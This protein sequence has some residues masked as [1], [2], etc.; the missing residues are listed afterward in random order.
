[1]GVLDV[2]NWQGV[3]VAPASTKFTVAPTWTRLDALDVKLRVAE[4][5]IRRGRSDEF[6]RTDTGTCAVGFKDRIGAVDPSAVNWISRPFAFAVRNPVTDTW[7]PRFRGHVEEHGWNL[8]PARLMGEVVIEAADALSYFAKVEM[9]P[10]ADVDGVP[11]FGHE[12][13]DNAAGRDIAGNVFY[14]GTLVEGPKLRIEA[15]LEQAG[16]PSGLRSIFTGN[17]NLTE[18]V[19][20][21]GESILAVMHDAADAE[22]PGVANLFVD[23]YGVVCFHG[24]NARFAPEDTADTATHWD[25]HDWSLG[26]GAT[27]IGSPFHVRRSSSM[28]RNSALC[29]PQKLQR[30]PESLIVFPVKDRV[31]QFVK[32]DGSI[33]LHGAHSW[34]ATDLVVKEGITSGLTGPQECRSYA[35]YIIA[36]YS[37]PQ[38]RL[39]QV[40]IRPVRPSDPRAHDIW[41]LLCN[42][43]ISDR[44][45]VGMAHPGGGGVSET[46]FVEGISETW[47]PLQYDLD[48]GYPF[49]EMVLDLSPAAYWGSLP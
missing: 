24:R 14:E 40:T 25:F 23:R 38:M 42:V 18:T 31:D 15:A 49:C 10:G 36:N 16:W 44:V 2:F 33:S 41:D 26:D 43:D 17:V 3:T 29:Y 47:R 1:M 45:T 21:P 37:Q 35:Q 19:Y 48:T 28:I 7:H 22:F 30:S 8:S 5:Q 9:Q 34:S 11:L 6:E 39:S 4:V 20:S 13:P 27:Q 32:D 46:F 12:I